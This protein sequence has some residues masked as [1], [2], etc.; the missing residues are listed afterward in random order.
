MSGFVPERL[1]RLCSY[2]YP[3]YRFA[4]EWLIYSHIRC[5]YVLLDAGCGGKGSSISRTPE[6]SEVIGIDVIK[7]NILASKQL[8]PGMKYVLGDL[9]AL[10][11]RENA[12]NGTFS[13]DVLEHVRHKK[14]V[15]TELSRTTK[16]GGFMIGSTTNLLNPI[17]GL[18]ANLP[19]RPLTAKYASGHYERHSRV[20]PSKLNNLLG[21]AGYRIN[22]LA[23]VGF[24]PLNAEVYQYT[25]RKAP[26]FAHV[27]IAF[28][29]LTLKKPFV[30][31]KENMIWVSSKD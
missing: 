26:W 5:G 2:N 8:C 7:K 29:K 21:E 11:F 4:L 25:N 20:S 6:D 1:W 31:L 18:D 16:K 28:D 15:I 27:W 22:I 30:Y 24:P 17:M 23:L 13:I 9:T 14:K 19:L 10:P 12:F 3:F